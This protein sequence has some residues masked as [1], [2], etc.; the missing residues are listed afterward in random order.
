M[1]VSLALAVDVLPEYR[2]CLADPLTLLGRIAAM[3]LAGVTSARTIS[4]ST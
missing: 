4:S 1:P 3:R 2:A